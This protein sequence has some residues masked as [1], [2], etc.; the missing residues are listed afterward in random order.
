MKGDNMSTA[1]VMVIGASGML[2]SMVTDFLSRDPELRISATVRSATLAEQGRGYFPGITWHVFDVE[3]QAGSELGQIIPDSSWVINCV[4]KTKPYTH[5]DNAEEIERA[6]KVNSLFPYELAEAAGTKASK[7]LSIATD[8][9]FSGERGDYVESDKHDALDVYG[10]TKSVGE[11]Y[12]PNA[13]NLRCS[14]IGPESKS[15]VFLL[16]WFRRQGKNARVNGF[17]NHRWNGVTTLQFARLCLGVIKENL[18]LPHIQ[19]VIPGDTI[20]KADLLNCFAREYN[21]EDVAI[22]PVEAPTVINRVLSTENRDLNAKLWMSAGYS[23]PPSVQ[24]MIAEMS[25][26]DFRMEAVFA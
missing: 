14:I 12:L 2:G 3:K 15:Y 22:T 25:R 7:V 4:G 18:D 23:S 20:S 10:K 24:G 17:T 1:N 6:I 26:F 9:V 5:D 13:Y 11:C 16:E 21:R 19:H 8:C